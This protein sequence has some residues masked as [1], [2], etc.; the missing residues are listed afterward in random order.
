MRSARSSWL[1]Y[2]PAV[3]YQR[4]SCPRHPSVL[5]PLRLYKYAIIHYRRQAAKGYSG[6]E[7][8]IVRRELNIQPASIWL[9]E[10][11]TNTRARKHLEF[12]NGGGTTDRATLPTTFFCVMSWTVGNKRTRSSTP[13]GRVTSL[14]W[15]KSSCSTLVW[16]GEP[17]SAGRPRIVR[18]YW[19]RSDGRTSRTNARRTTPSGRCA[20]PVANGVSRPSSDTITYPD[21]SPP[22]FSVNGLALEFF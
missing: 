9:Q 5:H 20:A 12:S 17:Q 15:H 21:L 7:D 14:P 3:S 10:A 8:H 11:A 19:S 6:T 22:C 16:R 1:H 4:G 2:Y 18:S 13:S